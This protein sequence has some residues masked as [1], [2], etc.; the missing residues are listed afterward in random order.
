MANQDN[1]EE[2]LGQ[3]EL[4]VMSFD[5]V[6]EEENVPQFEP[7]TKEQG[8][9]KVKVTLIDFVEKINEETGKLVQYTSFTLQDADGRQRVI[10]L[11]NPF[12]GKT[13]K[14]VI[15][16]L[17]QW[18]HIFNSFIDSPIKEVKN[19][20]GSKIKTK[21]C[22]IGFGVSKDSKNP[23]R[24]LFEKTMKFVVPN[25]DLLDVTVKLTYRGRN[26]TFPRYP[27]FIGTRLSGLD[28]STF[29]FDPK[30]DSYVP[31]EEAS[32]GTGTSGSYSSS[33]SSSSNADVE[34]EDVV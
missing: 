22:W 2:L 12:S 5:S 32:S 34:D 11:M 15:D 10:R 30:Y 33:S 31:T 4:N 20:R 23:F 1:I 19:A 9:N 14:I 16:N 18:K 25:Y 17:S 29:K 13:D 7:K 21:E 24:D 28:G 8:W 6:F 3:Q 26:V 27:D